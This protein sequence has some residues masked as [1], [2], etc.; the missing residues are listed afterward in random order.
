MALRDKLQSSVLQRQ[1]DNLTKK[2]D[3]PAFATGSSQKH[4]EYE[5]V[6]ASG[7][8]RKGKISGM[9][10][11]AVSQAL[12]ADGLMPIMLR[13]ASNSGLNKDLT[14]MM[15]GSQKRLRLTVPET[16][17]FFRQVS[18]LL[19]A[20][21]PISRVLV[22]LSEEASPKMVAICQGLLEKINAGVPLSEAM[23]AFPDAFDEVTRSYVSAGESSGT[24]PETMSRLARILEKR[25][26]MR[27]KIK[28]VTAYPKMVGG[29]IALI[30]GAILMFLVP[31]YQA[32][33]ADFGSELPLPTRILVAVSDNLFP[34]KPELSLSPFFLSGQPINPLSVLGRIV[35]AV[36]FIVITESMRNRA[37]KDP[38]ISRTVL[39]WVF[40]LT[41]TVFATGY[42][43]YPT[44]AIVWGIILATIFGVRYV[45]TMPTDNIKLAERVDTIRF[46]I[47]IFG[48]IIRRNA[49]FQWASTMGGAL[50]SGVPLTQA[51]A[52]AGA[53]AGS[54]WYA[55][56][57]QNLDGQVRA[58]KPLSEALATFPGLFSPSTRAMVS[59]G[60][61][62]GDLATMFVNIASTT[63]S[64][65]DSLVAGLS[66][67]VEVALLLVMA[68][69]VGG[70]LVALYMPIIQLATTVGGGGG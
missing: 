34:V 53:T 28:A 32:I 61:T 41:V 2:K 43:F 26:E 12:Q 42:V 35:F 47:P 67:K 7:V 60:E 48:G 4:F 65:I 1:L 15:G 27:L 22:A 45:M 10:Q 58:G 24:L 68:V 46:R 50:S 44:S 20:G 25:N 69:V 13:P 3:A 23:Q 19:K 5:A 21:V 11:Q 56:A 31:R 38:K 17:A 36:A 8:R 66:A 49:L 37:G 29:A 55:L 63:D 51:L 33:Y 62:T 52:L 54:R 14:S 59:T 39:K 30:V 9:S 64:E 70:L 16:A 57:A 40:V 6:T 18:E